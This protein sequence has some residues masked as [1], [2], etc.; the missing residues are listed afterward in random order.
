[1]GFGQAVVWLAEVIVQPLEGEVERAVGSFAD[2]AE[3]LGI[4]GEMLHTL[5]LTT[6]VAGRISQGSGK[7]SG[8]DGPP[9][10]WGEF[11]VPLASYEREDRLKA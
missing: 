7:I 1:V 11:G 9:L 5:G 6:T 3:V 10:V 4:W 8:M 2:E